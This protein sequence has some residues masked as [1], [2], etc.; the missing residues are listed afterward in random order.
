MVGSA[1]SSDW[2]VNQLLEPETEADFESLQMESTE[3]Q[4]PSELR[5][6][7]PESNTDYY[8]NLVKAS[9][10]HDGRL[11]SHTIPIPWLRMTLAGLE[12]RLTRVEDM[13]NG[14]RS[15]EPGWQ[16]EPSGDLG[17]PPFDDIF[18]AG[19]GASG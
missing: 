5:S 18:D 3:V 13:W 17:R 19:R 11:G 7:S 6:E 15:G 2:D 10:A 14:P 9:I 4:T 12:G 8:V 1:G 16:T